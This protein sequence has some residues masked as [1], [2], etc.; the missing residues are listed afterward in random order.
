VI[1]NFRSGIAAWLLLVLALDPVIGVAQPNAN[2]VMEPVPQQRS[3]RARPTQQADPAQDVVP[4][5]PSTPIDRSA[6]TES[7]QVT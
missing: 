3:I 7:A 6:G 5:V 1:Q 4:A 2:R